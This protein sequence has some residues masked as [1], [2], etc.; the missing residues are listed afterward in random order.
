MR[1]TT[2]LDFEKANHYIAT[3][4]KI[5]KG[6]VFRMEGY[7]KTYHNLVKTVNT[8]PNNEG[9]GYARGVDF[10]FKD[11]KTIKNGDYYVSYS[12]LDTKRDYRNFPTLATPIFAPKHNFN[13]VYKHWLNSLH[14]MI[15]ATYSFHS[16]RPFNDPNTTD[17]NA[18]RTANYHDLSFNMAYITNVKSNFTVVYASVSNVLGFNQVSGYRFSNSPNSEGRFQSTAITP[19][20]KRFIVVG[21]LMTIGQKFEKNK[22]NNDDI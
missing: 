2:A 7:Y 11:S 10:F 22:E 16:G 4:E 1:R 13:V 8:L 15:G 21:L 17:F 9:H 20:A 18:G 19:P 12:Y 14:T 3:Y 6:Y 5:A